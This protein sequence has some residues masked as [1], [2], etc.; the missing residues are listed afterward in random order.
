MKF[1]HL[2][3]CHIGGWREP[4]LTRIGIEA[5]RK[6]ID[7]CIKENTAFILISG[8]LFNTS[9]P[10]IELIKE[11]AAILKKAK[12]K[13]ISCYVIPGSHDF[14]PSGKTILD[15]LEKSGL[16]EN[17][18]KLNKNKLSFTID[19]T[20]T[21]ITGLY[22]KRG[23]L[24]S[25]DYKTLDKTNLEK[26]QG[27]KIFLFHTL[28]NELNPDKF[29]ISNLDTIESLPKNFN[30]YAGGHPHFIYSK[31]YGNGIVAYP[32]PLFPNNF[33]ELEELKHGGFYLVDVKGA[34]LSLNYTPVKIK[35]TIS[36][37]IN[38]EN[39]TP[40]EVEKQI[41]SSLGKKEIKD[42]IITLRIEGILSAGKPSDI[43][44]KELLNKF[45]EAYFIIKNTGKLKNKE[46]A[47]IWAEGNSADEIEL[48][49][50]KE[51]IGKSNLFMDEEKV[52]RE[53]MHILDKEK[54]EGER[55]FDFE[56]RITKD[57]N[58]LFGVKDAAEKD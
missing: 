37:V 55:S 50:I 13:G 23:G 15:V 33:S 26:E 40:E 45:K 24:E 42:K 11:T 41:L 16:I 7:T 22:G 49:I 12:S 51:N 8:D 38:A 5:F 30:Y 46:L 25:V 47:E 4:K 9:L 17:V 57:V 6:A 10:A 52:T 2:A 29:V 54:G 32:G 21:K 28:F 20:N 58:K 27:F 44:F 34:K 43:S 31:E 53:L 1:A 48:K 3:D 18:V 36:L 19:K 39:K 14:S 56:E 35:E